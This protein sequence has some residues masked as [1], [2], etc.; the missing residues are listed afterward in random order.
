MTMTPWIATLCGLVV[1][2]IAAMMSPDATGIA[3]AVALG[4]WISALVLAFRAASSFGFALDAIAK[5]NLPRI[6]LAA[7]VM[8][9]LLWLKM[10]IIWP[11]TQDAHTLGQA[12]V[13]SVLIAGGLAIYGGLLAL[14]GVLDLAAIRNRLRR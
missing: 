7:V 12:L 11:L 3:V 5:R 9:A 13:L 14:T 2:V 8:A 6:V 1:A 4:A 10:R